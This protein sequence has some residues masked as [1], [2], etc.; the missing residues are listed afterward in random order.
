[1]SSGGLN[2]CSFPDLSKVTIVFKSTCQTADETEEGREADCVRS[3]SSRGAEVINLGTRG[4]LADFLHPV[5]ESS[6][7]FAVHSVVL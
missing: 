3:C 2:V 4:A 1:M 5:N 7:I 6:L